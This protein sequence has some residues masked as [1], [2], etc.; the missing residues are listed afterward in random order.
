MFL[1]PPLY[2]LERCKSSLAS[3]TD[4]AALKWKWRMQPQFVCEVTSVYFTTESPTLV[5]NP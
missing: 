5:G 3:P 4:I 2:G 1:S